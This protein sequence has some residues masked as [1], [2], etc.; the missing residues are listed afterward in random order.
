MKYSPKCEICGRFISHQ[1]YFEGKTDAEVI[2]L[3]EFTKEEITH[4]HLD[5]ERK[6]RQ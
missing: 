2:P 6:E 5:C 4:W 3:S 1:D